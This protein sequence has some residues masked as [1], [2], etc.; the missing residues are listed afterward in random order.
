[1]SSLRLLLLP[2]SLLYGAVVA[3]RN[4]M[5]DVGLLRR[6]SVSAKVVSVGNIGVGG[7]GKTP[8]VEYVARALQRRG[9]RVAVLSRGYGRVTSGYVVVSNGRQRCAES[10]DSGDE[11]AQM[12]DKLEGVVVAVDADRVRG[13]NRLIRE[14]GVDAIVLDD[15]FQHRYLNRDVDLVVIPAEDARS[16][17]FLLPAGNMR[18]PRS[19]LRRADLIVLSRCRD[20]HQFSETRTALREKLDKPMVAMRMHP[21]LLHHVAGG[22]VASVEEVSGRRVVAF[23]GIGHPEGFEATLRGL[24]VEL[25]DHLR[26]GDHH[27]FRDGDIRTV[28]EVFIRSHA[29]MVLTTEKDAVRLRGNQSL[30]ERY[31]RQHPVYAVE[32]RAEVFEGND[33]LETALQQLD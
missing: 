8:L 11:P 2:F 9:R 17:G 25:V 22:N 28:V 14:F 23:S 19:S 31:L 5:F 18:E 7:T 24:N 13:A 29:A 15:G 30:L 32:V 33:L 27:E 4:W 16:T 21:T 6:H 12:A 1:M 20:R 10:W 26:F 3:V